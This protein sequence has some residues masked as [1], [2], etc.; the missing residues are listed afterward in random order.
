MRAATGVTV[1]L[2]ATTT[3]F[4]AASG[5]VVDP[6]GKPITAAE[7]CTITKVV[8]GD[9]RKVNELGYYHVDN[10]PSLSLFVRASGYQPQKIAAVAQS[11]PVVLEQAATLRVEVLDAASRQPVA[12]GTVILNYASGQQIG[13][14][15]PFNSKGVRI[16]TL[17]PGEVLI[18]AEAPGYEGGGPEAVT[19]IAG[20]ETG[21][22]IS[23]KKL[24]SAAR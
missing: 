8:T 3:L 16:T 14:S 18:R 17:A 21:I 23:M 10:P 4:A 19:A 22:A 24:P 6:F 5:R 7:V 1:L 9:C 12:K 13:T 11:A 2:L 15:V 20:K